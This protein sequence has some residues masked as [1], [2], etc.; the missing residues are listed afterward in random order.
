MLS[1][2]SEMMS[3]FRSPGAFV[4]RPPCSRAAVSLLIHIGP[5]SWNIFA[6]RKLDQRS[7]RIFFASCGIVCGAWWCATV[8]R[9][10]D[11][12]SSSTGVFSHASWYRSL[13]Y[14][15]MSESSFD[16]SS[17]SKSATALVKERTLSPDRI[18]LCSVWCVLCKRFY[19]NVFSTLSSS[20][21]VQVPST[22]LQL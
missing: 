4:E 21:R 22:A 3:F 13:G 7:C 6:K 2:R 5:E 19:G 17:Y 16:R 12:S 20:S 10:Q 1:K 18:L 15:E 11:R 9:S 14:G 8:H